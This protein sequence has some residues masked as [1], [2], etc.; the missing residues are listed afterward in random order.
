MSSVGVWTKTIAEAVDVI[1][2]YEAIMGKDDMKVTVRAALGRSEAESCTSETLVRINGAL[3]QLDR[4]LN[5][6]E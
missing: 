6:L 4:R 2:R 3:D 5:R 1:E